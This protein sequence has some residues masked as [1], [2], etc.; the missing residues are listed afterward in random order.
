MFFDDDDIAD[1]TCKRKSALGPRLLQTVL[2]RL[3]SSEKQ[4]FIIVSEI[5]TPGI[6]SWVEMAGGVG[7]SSYGSIYL[8]MYALTH[9][10]IDVSTC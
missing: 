9:P 3:K 4:N 5:E 7:R 1:P 2:L 8:S 6:L 10:S